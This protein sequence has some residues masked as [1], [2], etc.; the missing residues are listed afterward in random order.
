MTSKI[1]DVCSTCHCINIRRAAYVMTNYYNRILAP[2]GVTIAQYALLMNLYDLGQCS[3]S[4]LAR[5]R[6]LERSTLVRNLKPLF[7]AGLVADESQPGS[8]N[9]VLVLTEKGQA[10]RKAAMP[11]WK[12]AQKGISGALGAERMDEFDAVM[13]IISD[14]N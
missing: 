11:L 1:K 9:R 10:V 14:L 2:S 5:R 6:G 8:R 12:K 7:A 4:E 13:Q 3:V